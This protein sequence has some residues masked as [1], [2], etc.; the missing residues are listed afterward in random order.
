MLINNTNINILKK[1]FPHLDDRSRKPINVL[2]KLTELSEC[3][4]DISNPSNLE[5]CSN[6]YTP[7][8]TEELLRDIRPECPKEGKEIIDLILNFSKTK[9]FYNTYKTLNN[10]TQA[11]SNKTNSAMDL[12]KNQLSPEQLERI[13]EL[14]TILNSTHNFSEL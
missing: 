11:T 3:I 8:N 12:L 5:S 14:S 6:M 4:N 7:I 13:N 1:A 10:L 2:L 9:D